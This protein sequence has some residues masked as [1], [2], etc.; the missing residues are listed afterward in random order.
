MGGYHDTCLQCVLLLKQ[1]VICP[2][3][4]TFTQHQFFPKVASRVLCPEIDVTQPIS[5][6][7]FTVYLGVSLVVT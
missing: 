1:E 2:F 5:Q 4:K 6:G 3:I 7:A